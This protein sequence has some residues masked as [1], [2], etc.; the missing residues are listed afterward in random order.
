MDPDPKKEANALAAPEAEGETVGA[1]AGLNGETKD[2]VAPKGG[3]D[4]DDDD[5]G[6]VNVKEELELEVVNPNPPNLGA[7]DTGG[8]CKTIRNQ[9]ICT[10]KFFPVKSLAILHCA[11]HS[12]IGLVQGQ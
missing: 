5:E 4:D 2:D 6:V 12:L 11:T 7:D 3:D 1:T 9:K 10:S 8:I